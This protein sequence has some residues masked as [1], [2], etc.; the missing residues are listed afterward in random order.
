MG[1]YATEELE[2]ANAALSDATQLRNVGG[3]DEAIVNR[4]Y[5]ACYH[6]AKG[7]L[8][9]KGF[10]PTTHQGV[11]SLFGEKVV[12]AGKASKDAGRFLNNMRDYR[13]TADYE[14]TSVSVDIDDIDKLHE[15]TE[16]F[17]AEIEEMM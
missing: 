3:R 6:A 17:V 15:Q 5:Y 1:E 13:T 2:E 7:V 4:L 14:H 11:I 16:Q 9:A 12:L 8:Y 10:E